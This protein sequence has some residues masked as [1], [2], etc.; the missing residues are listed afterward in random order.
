MEDVVQNE[1]LALFKDIVHGNDLKT[2]E[3]LLV[4]V[5][6]FWGGEFVKIGT[7]NVVHGLNV[8]VIDAGLYSIM[9]NRL[10]FSHPLEA[11]WYSLPQQVQVVPQMRTKQLQEEPF[12][13]PRRWAHGY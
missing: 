1:I 3:G 7:V 2:Y 13:F 11:V 8:A 10:E 6:Y 4:P 9:Y 5:G 12:G